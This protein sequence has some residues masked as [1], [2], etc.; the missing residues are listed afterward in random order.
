MDRHKGRTTAVLPL[1][2]LTVA[3]ITTPVANAQRLATQARQPAGPTLAEQ[4]VA[5]ALAANPTIAPY[6]LATS[7]DRQGRV[8][9]SGRVGSKGIYDVVIR[10]LIALG[11]PFVDRL[12]IDT[13][14]GLPVA[15]PAVVARPLLYPPP[16]MGRVDEPF[17]GFEPPVIAY[18]PWWGPLSAQRRAE[19]AAPTPVAPSPERPAPP[20]PFDEP[21]PATAPGQGQGPGPGAANDREDQPPPPPRPFDQQDAMPGPPP[22]QPP[23]RPRMVPPPPAPGVPIAPV[24]G[25]TAAATAAGSTA[26][27][28]DQAVRRALAADVVDDVQVTITTDGTATLAGELPSVYEAMLAFRAVEKTPGVSALVDRLRFPVPSPDGENPL[29]TRGRPEDVEPYLEAQLA[30]HLGDQ[31]HIDRVRVQ[32][33]LL[34]IVGTVPEQD[35]RARVLA[36]LRSLPILRGYRIDP[37]FQAE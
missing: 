19:P 33:D 17:L 12:V 32:A 37:S 15:T 8:V 28:A 4:A 3:T 14:M 29:I 36:V 30:R 34:Q 7:M 18:P 24:P 35:D 22:P 13:A 6:Q 25:P 2:L 11:V 21:P 23:V 10:T 16:L 26:S 27:R 20:R 31:A 1:A 9:V 5:D